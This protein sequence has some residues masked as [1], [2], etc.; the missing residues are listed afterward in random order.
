MLFAEDK[1]IV[2]RWFLMVK[3]AFV[4]TF[5]PKKNDEWN[6]YA[7]KFTQIVLYSNELDKTR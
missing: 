2:L 1:L 4:L 3:C 6:I 5:T 7:N